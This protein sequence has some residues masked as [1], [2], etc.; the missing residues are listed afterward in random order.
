MPPKKQKGGPGRA[1]PSHLLVAH[2]ATAITDIV[3]TRPPAQGN[4]D[5]RRDYADAYR[6]S[7]TGIIARARAAA[8][9][10]DTPADA[11]ENLEMLRAVLHTEVDRAVDAEALRRPSP[12]RIIFR[13]PRYEVRRA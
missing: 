7:H 6:A 9:L 11:L 8:A 12:N 4:T 10:A 3:P 13:A 5:A 1:R 2:Q